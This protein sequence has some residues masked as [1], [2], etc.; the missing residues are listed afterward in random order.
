MASF[1]ELQKEGLTPFALGPIYVYAGVQEDIVRRFVSEQPKK[2]MHYEIKAGIGYIPREDNLEPRGAVLEFKHNVL[3]FCREWNNILNVLDSQSYM[4]FKKWLL[5][6]QFANR[7]EKKFFVPRL[8]T[9]PVLDPVALDLETPLAIP[10]SLDVYSVS[11]MKGILY[12]KDMGLPK[13]HA[14]AYIE[15]VH[16]PPEEDTIKLGSAALKLLREV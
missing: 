15:F 11:G 6:Q 4:H 2:A 16:R 7:A 8:F 5:A 14:K 13:E 3:T 9:P 1:A 10:T 12:P